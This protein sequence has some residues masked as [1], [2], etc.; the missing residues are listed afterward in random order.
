MLGKR[1]RGRRG[2][3]SAGPAPA[4]TFPL[5]ACPTAPATGSP[6]HCHLCCLS[7]FPADKDDKDHAH[8]AVPPVPGT[9]PSQV[10][11]GRPERE[12]VASGAGSLQAR[13]EGGRQAV[14]CPRPTVSAGAQ[15]RGHSNRLGRSSREGRCSDAPGHRGKP[16]HLNTPCAPRGLTS[17]RR[18]RTR[19][20]APFPLK[21]QPGPPSLWLI[22]RTERPL[23]PR[24][25]PLPPGLK[26][27]GA[28]LETRRP[29]LDPCP[30]VPVS[31]DACGW[32]QT[33]CWSGSG[34]LRGGNGWPTWGDGHS[35]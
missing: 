1:S 9:V 17:P 14:P 34:P 25:W 22:P 26:A 3:S 32:G 12:N 15:G 13:R 27:S 20:A 24:H 10:Q 28:V 7:L 30:S 29:L 8:P 2:Q 21:E 18:G 35:V 16:A 11:T 23:C 19:P 31:G 5:R 6:F 4:P 33:H